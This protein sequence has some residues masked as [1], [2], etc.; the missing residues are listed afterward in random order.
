MVAGC[1]YILAVLISLSILFSPFTLIGNIINGEEI[2]SFT[3]IS[4]IIVGAIYCYGIYSIFN[5][6]KE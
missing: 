2:E 6:G 1:A 3:L 5:K 4:G